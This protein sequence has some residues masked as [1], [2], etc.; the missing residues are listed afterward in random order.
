MKNYT[1]SCLHYFH[2]IHRLLIMSTRKPI[3]N[4]PGYTASNAG[5][6]YAPSG[7]LAP[8]R[9]IN[10]Y[11]VVMVRRGAGERRSRMRGWLVLAAFRPPGYPYRVCHVN[12]NNLDDALENLRAA[13]SGSNGQPSSATPIAGEEWRPIPETS[14][15]YEASSMGR[16]RRALSKTIVRGARVGKAKAY[17]QVKLS[18]GHKQLL[19]MQVSRAVLSAFRGPAPEGHEADHK[20]HDTMN[21]TLDNLRWR[22]WA[23]NRGDQL[24]TKARSISTLRPVTPAMVGAV[25][26]FVTAGGTQYGASQAFGM[27]SSTVGTICSGKIAVAR[28]VAAALHLSLPAGTP[29]RRG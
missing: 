12:D 7:E 19:A 9:V 5:D 28:A 27:P 25:L 11:A 4:Y 1:F 14:G 10:G 2:T 18:L 15:V 21:N 17:L 6:V 3:P 22:P 20:N 26:G 8:T 23:D 24:R 13:P 29:A 16:V